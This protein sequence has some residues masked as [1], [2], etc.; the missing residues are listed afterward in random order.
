MTATIG[1][2]PDYPLGRR[3]RVADLDR[4]PY[5][6]LARLRAEEPVTWVDELGLWFVT[7]R[8]LAVEV[9][10]DPETFRNDSEESLIRDTFGPQML[11][12]EGET[13]LRHRRACQ[14]AFGRRTLEEEAAARIRE[15]AG[16]LVERLRPAG[17]ADIRPGLASPLAILS[18]A[19]LLGLPETEHGRLREWYDAFAAALA[20][21]QREP[22][23]RRRGREAA[24]ACRARFLELL[25]G[26]HDGG[27]RGLLGALVRDSAL[28]EDE[29][30]R[31]AMIIL[32]GGIETAE[33]LILDSVWA[34]LSHPDVHRR[35]SAERGLVPAAV[36]ET[37]RWEPAVQSLSRHAAR[38]VELGGARIRSGDLVQCMTGGA[39]RDPA[40]FE[41]PD[42]FDLDRPNAGHHLT[43][44]YGIH[45]CIGAHLGRLE[46]RVALETLLD[47]LPGI[48]LDPDRPAAPRGYEFR[49]PPAL[50]LRWGP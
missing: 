31:N 50:H 23:V 19:S 18:V 34:V 25:A 47:A 6:I 5:P 17:E 1:T 11:S 42:T 14:P 33:S 36:E 21:F 2:A 38:D 13:H 22:G 10:S 9:L 48:R 4:D 7:P 32:F 29:I 30:I 3:V 24:R 12:T 37:L 44:G 49:K 39:N 41:D 26:P 45:F 27:E 16:A 8:A 28:S 15:R 35:V 40:Y 46:A 43:F 20:N